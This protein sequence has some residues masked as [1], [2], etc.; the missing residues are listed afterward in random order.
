MQERI[1]EYL[2]CDK[3]AFR[4][5]AVKRAADYQPDGIISELM[6]AVGMG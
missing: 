1:A 5:A 4:N 3:A 6:D 2:Q